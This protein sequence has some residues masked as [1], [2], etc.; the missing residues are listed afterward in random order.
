MH[1]K[2]ESKP[3][4]KLS[5]TF[6]ADSHQKHVTF[7]E[8]KTSQLT[9]QLAVEQTLRKK[10]EIDA[11]SL[12]AAQSA[13]AA[14][15]DAALDAVDLLNGRVAWLEQEL[16]HAQRQNEQIALLT[17]ERNHLLL[18]LDAAENEARRVSLLAEE[19]RRNG[20]RF[21]ALQEELGLLTEKYAQEI[22]E[23][24]KLKQQMAENCQTA[25]SNQSRP[26]YVRRV[27]RQELDRLE[28]IQ[29]IRNLN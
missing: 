10:L 28:E 1:T 9:K 25:R 8:H 26:P 6:L 19:L 15:K 21:R 14:E 22:N 7:L 27:T 16:L 12:R 5:E 23:N 4:T 11:A 17:D 3:K 2:T 24:C 13:A 29:Q 20:D 18:R